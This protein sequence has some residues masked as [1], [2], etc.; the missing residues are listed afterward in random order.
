MSAETVVLSRTWTVGKRTVTFTVP[1]PKPGH[2]VHCCCE[3]SPDE[4]QR[5]AGTEWL[6]YVAGRNA[7]IAELA[8]ELG[9]NVAVIDA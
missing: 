8:H 4:P 3:W 1:Q 7:A 5:L 9:V 6:Q 2:A